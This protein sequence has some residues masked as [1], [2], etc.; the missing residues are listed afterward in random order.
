[1]TPSTKTALILGSLLALL[2]L[3]GLLYS[4]RGWLRGALSESGDGAPSSSRL[5]AFLT[6]IVNVTAF[7]GWGSY[8]VFGL[9][10]TPDL[11]A[12]G[13]YMGYSQ[14]GGSLPYAMNMLRRGLSERSALQVAPGPAIPASGGAGAGG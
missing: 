9:G 11:T 6:A 1:M 2:A 4:A 14:A 3:A 7:A 13:T 5:I 12:W 8:Q 10:Q